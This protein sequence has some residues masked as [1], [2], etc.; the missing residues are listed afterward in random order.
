MSN[1]SCCEY[2]VST[3]EGRLNSI[4][5]CTNTTRFRRI[6]T[7]PTFPLHDEDFPED[8]LILILAHL[9]KQDYLT[10][11][12]VCKRWDLLRHSVATVR[13]AIAT[14]IQ[15]K[16]SVQYKKNRTGSGLWQWSGWQKP[17]PSHLWIRLS[18]WIKFV[19]EVP[20]PS[21]NFGL[22]LHGRLDNSWVKNCRPNTWKHITSVGPA[23]GGDGN[24]IL[25]I[26]DSIQKRTV[27]RFTELR[28]E[29]IDSPQAKV[30]I[31]DFVAFTSNHISKEYVA[32]GIDRIGIP[33]VNGAGSM[34]FVSDYPRVGTQKT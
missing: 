9:S 26:F 28:L 1:V 17:I 16:R 21:S 18:C 32:M 5:I 29:I 15:V 27:I 33:T 6:E 12:I 8:L 14:P 3:L 24:H 19:G 31:K 11:K 7:I 34:D 25:L 22:K 4:D 10:C 2:R 13:K 30:P 20:A 23:M